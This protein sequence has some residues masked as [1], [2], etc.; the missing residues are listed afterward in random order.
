MPTLTGSAVK[1]EPPIIKQEPVYPEYSSTANQS[2]G[3]NNVP[4]SYG[5][6]NA[7]A[8]ARA[9]GH[10][11]EKFGG[12]ASA[13]VNQLQAQAHL[14][15]K[16]NPPPSQ[17]ADARQQYNQQMA[18]AMKQQQHA[19]NMPPQ[20]RAPVAAAQTDGS[21][22]W[23]ATVEERRTVTHTSTREADLTI[24]QMVEQNALQMEGGGLMLP[25][26]ERANTRSQLVSAQKQP[27]KGIPQVDGADL[28]D[29]VKAEADEDAINSD[30]D[31][32][33]DD[34]IGET[35]DDPSTGELMLC[36][37]DVSLWE[38]RAVV[39]SF[40]KPS[41]PEGATRQE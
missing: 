13:Q 29:D 24:R 3:R 26:S 1:Q 9:A 31:D 39:L 7:T 6:P 40:T 10:L 21:S 12:A 18:N 33:D 22:D 14:A 37:Y 30:L 2:G 25:A 34:A 36:T 35:E 20:Q 5:A 41:L 17:A 27:S 32:P 38:Y 16:S 23:D 8:A 4:S 28:D 11:H 15:Q 19:N